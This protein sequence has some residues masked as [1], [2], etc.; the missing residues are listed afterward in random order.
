MHGL[1]LGRSSCDASLPAGLRSNCGLVTSRPLEK[2]VASAAED[3]LEP[4]KWVAPID[5]LVGLGWLASSRV[6]E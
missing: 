1:R 2:R 6:D 5:V 3:A 4:R